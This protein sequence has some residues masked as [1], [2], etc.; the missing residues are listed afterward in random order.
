MNVF[1]QLPFIA[2]FFSLL[3][4][5]FSV[6]RKRPS[7]ATWCFFAG[8]TALGAD[9]ILTGLSLRAARPAAV[10]SF[11]PAT[12]LVKCFIPVIW[13]GFSLTYSRSGYRQFLHRWR[14]ALAVIGLLPVT[15]W[16]VFQDELVQVVPDAVSGSWRLQFG[17]I[18][19]AL[20]AVL[21]VALVLIM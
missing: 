12:S 15:I 2:G 20:N 21:L 11:L 17:A 5:G 14:V 4:A 1:F 18:A 6:V 9:S 3:L 19:T 7:A 8:M 10:N 13:L 16:L